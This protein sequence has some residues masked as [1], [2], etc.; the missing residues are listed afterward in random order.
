MSDRRRVH[1]LAEIN[2]GTA[3]TAMIKAFGLYIESARAISIKSVQ[4][5]FE[6]L[7]TVNTRR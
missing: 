1:E 6:R 3:F 7:G 2:T 4:Y 5:I